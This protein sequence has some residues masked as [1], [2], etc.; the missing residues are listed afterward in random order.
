VKLESV[1]DLG[2]N[3]DR[4]G[5]PAGHG[6]S[7]APAYA[8]RRLRLSGARRQWRKGG[9]SSPRRAPQMLAIPGVALADD[10]AGDRS[11]RSLKL[12]VDVRKFF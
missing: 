7:A 4:Q 9:L 3:F 6:L 8:S 12:G 5:G 2:R 10:G 1:F 11:N